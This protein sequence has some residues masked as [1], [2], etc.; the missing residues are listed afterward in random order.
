MGYSITRFYR[1][2]KKKLFDEIDELM[3]NSGYD[4]KDFD[5]RGGVL[6]VRYI[7]PIVTF[8]EGWIEIT[9]TDYDL[10]YSSVLPT[11]KI[12]QVELACDDTR[13]K[14]MMEIVVERLKKYEKAD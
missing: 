11:E 13:R 8:F 4:L 12:Y 14:E 3:R 7:E 1:A 6:K 2:G 10:I 5:D 9:I